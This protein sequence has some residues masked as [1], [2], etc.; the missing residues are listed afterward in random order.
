MVL[1]TA[2]SSKR[3]SSSSVS[4]FRL[5]SDLTKKVIVYLPGEE[6][7]LG[8]KI[9]KHVPK[10]FTPGEKSSLTRRSRKI[11]PEEAFEVVHDYTLKCE[12]KRK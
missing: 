7:Q 10:K 1:L 6:K 2:M 9:I 4:S 12:L 11:L 8:E 3:R 5:F